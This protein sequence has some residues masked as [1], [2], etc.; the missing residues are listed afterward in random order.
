MDSLTSGL[1]G[2]LGTH[3]Q[4]GP[5]RHFSVEDLINEPLR[6]CPF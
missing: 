3:R 4:I 5:G 6:L 2:R 1:K